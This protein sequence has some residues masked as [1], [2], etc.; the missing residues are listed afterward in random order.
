MSKSLYDFM[1]DAKPLT[2]YKIPLTE[3]GYYFRVNGIIFTDK[4]CAAIISAINKE[5][6]FIEFV[7]IDNTTFKY[8]DLN[9]IFTFVDVFDAYFLI[10]CYNALDLPKKHPLKKVINVEFLDMRGKAGSI[11]SKL[12]PII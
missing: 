8:N 2:K 7:P 3:D 6:K 10:K 11:I 12:K 1:K 9:Q 4:H 5:E